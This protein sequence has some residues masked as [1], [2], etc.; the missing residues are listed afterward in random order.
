MIIAWWL[1]LA[2]FA[3]AFVGVFLVGLANGNRDDRE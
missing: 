3:G 2:F 1:V